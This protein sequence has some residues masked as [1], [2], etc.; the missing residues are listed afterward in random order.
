MPANRVAPGTSSPQQACARR[1]AGRGAPDGVPRPETRYKALGRAVAPVM[2]ARHATRDTHGTRLVACCVRPAGAR[3]R[4]PVEGRPRPAI[5][6]R[7]GHWSFRRWGA[8]WGAPWG[9]VEEAGRAASRI[10]AMDGSA[11]L[12]GS[13]QVNA[14]QKTDG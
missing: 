5:A 9:R 8:S 6:P 14:A 12:L 7:A 13:G 2:S 10:T 11:P 1:R 3:R 4:R